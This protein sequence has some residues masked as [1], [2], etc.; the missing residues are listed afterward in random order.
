M[1]RI[2]RYVLATDGGMAPNPRGR[3]VTLATCKPEIRRTARQGDWVIGNYPSPHNRL[4]A[5]AGRVE[6]CIPVALYSS[7]FPERDD[8][9]HEIGADG[10]PQRISGKHN[11][12]HPEGG[13][14]RKDRSGN[15]LV[16]DQGNCW[17]FGSDGRCLPD[18]I[19][20][21]AAVGQGH[22]LNQ[23]VE[24]DLEVLEAWLAEQGPPG[25]HGEP[26]D[27]WAGPTRPGFGPRSPKP[28]KKPSSC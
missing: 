18:S 28:P 7:E 22:R 2:Y 6:K 8:A 20:H 12:Y 21:L 19:A 26:R 4:V 13:Q 5:W 11:W 15:A 3:H 14:R 23:R 17:Y 16:F 1:T 27:G 9:L 24:G 25:I 10:E